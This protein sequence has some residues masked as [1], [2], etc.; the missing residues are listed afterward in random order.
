MQQPLPPE[1]AAL[2]PHW[3]RLYLAAP[4]LVTRRHLSELLG[5]L[6][7]PETLANLDCEGSGPA[8]RV[9][10]GRRIAYP[11]LDAVLWAA[12][13]ERQACKSHLQKCN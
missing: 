12:G 10:L 2:P 13:C 7:A 6:Y 3:Q 9:L 5:G 11:R 4:E 8:N 1:I